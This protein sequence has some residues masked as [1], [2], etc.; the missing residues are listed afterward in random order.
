MLRGSGAETNAGIRSL[1]GRRAVVLVR[2][3]HHFLTALVDA[4][5]VDVV[6]VDVVQGSVL[7]RWG[8][9]EVVMGAWTLLHGSSA[10]LRHLLSSH[11]RSAAEIRLTGDVTAALTTVA[12]AGCPLNLHQCF[13]LID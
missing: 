2:Q 9:G 12:H 1:D 8:V 5:V 11:E 13:V 3:I 4:A 7:L 6:V 10:S